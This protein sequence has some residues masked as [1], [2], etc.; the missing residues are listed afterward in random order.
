[1]LKELH[2]KTILDDDHDSQR[3]HICTRRKTRPHYDRQFPS[4]SIIAVLHVSIHPLT[5]VPSSA[6]TML[7]SSNLGFVCTVVICLGVV[8]SC[9][10]H[11]VLA[12]VLNGNCAMTTL[13]NTPGDVKD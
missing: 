9:P 5:L 6:L 12:Y 11:D 3:L 4:Q 10:E 1:M 13:E 2:A 8:P 7:A